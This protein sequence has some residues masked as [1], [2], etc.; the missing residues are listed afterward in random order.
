LPA[1]Y[2]GLLPLALNAPGTSATHALGPG[3]QALDRI[4]LGGSGC[5]TVMSADQRDEPRPEGEGG[6]CDIGAYEK[7]PFDPISYDL[8][9]PLGIK[10]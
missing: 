9:L 10:P 4:P 7:G 3:S 8:Y 5:G 1:A 6:L 2:A